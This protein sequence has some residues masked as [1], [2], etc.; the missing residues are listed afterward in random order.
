MTQSATDPEEQFRD[1]LVRYDEA[2]A[3][4][5]DGLIVE[6]QSWSSGLHQEAHQQRFDRV[7]SCLQLLDQD[8]RRLTASSMDAGTDGGA[9]VDES[10]AATS[11]GSPV[12]QQIGRFRL[13]RRLGSGGF[14]MVFLAEDPTLERLVAV[15]IPRPETLA[16]PDLQRRFVQESQLAARLTHP[17]LVPIYEAGQTESFSYQVT[18]Y[19][20]GGNLSQW[21]GPTGIPSGMDPRSQQRDAAEVPASAYAAQRQLSVSVAVELLTTLADGLQY[22]HEHG[23]LHRDLKPSNILLQ[24]RGDWSAAAGR[25]MVHDP[26][27]LEELCTTFQPMISDFGLAKLFAAAGA[28]AQSGDDAPISEL[29]LSTKAGTP[30][31]MAPEQFTGNVRDI[32][33]A[34][35]VYGLGAILYEVLTGRCMFRQNSVESLRYQVTEVQPAGLRQLRRDV[36]RDLEAI[37][38]KCLAKTVPE[39]Y[40][41]ARNLAN[42]LRAFSRGDAVAARPWPWYEQ[43]AK[44][45]KKRPAV[46]SLLIVSSLLM[47]GLLSFGAWHV[48]QLNDLND[49][50][51]LSVKELETHT[52]VAQ[53]ESQRAGHQAR[54]ASEKE[55]LAKLHAHRAAELAWIARSRAYST[56]LLRAAE[57]FQA[58]KI[59]AIGAILQEQ[60]LFPGEADERGFAWHYLWSLGRNM[61]ELPG[62]TTATVCAASLTRDGKTC[63]AISHDGTIR[64]WDALTGILQQMWIL[65]GKGSVFAKIDRDTTRAV[66]RR[67]GHEESLPMVV[68]WDLRQG[69]ELRRQEFSDSGIADVAIAP[70]GSWSL[71]GG[72]SNGIVSSPVLLWSIDSGQMTRMELPESFDRPSYG[73]NAV[74]ISPDGR[75]CAVAVHSS[76]DNLSWIHQLFRADVRY[77]GVGAGSSGPRQPMTAPRISEWICVKPP[78]AGIER[79]LKYSPDGNTISMAVSD[80]HK[81]KVEVWE[82]GSLRLLDVLEDGEREFDEMAF[83][84]PE[85]TLA[86]SGVNHEVKD[87]PSRVTVG[88]GESTDSRPELTFWNVKK[89]THETTSFPALDRITS[90]DFHESSRVWIIGEYEGRLSLWRPEV[91]SQYRDLPGHQ[92]DET[93]GVAFSPDGQTVY[94]VGDDWG[95]RAWNVVTGLQ[96]GSGMHHRSLV[97]CLAVSPDGRWVATGSYDDDVILWDADS[98]SVHSV[99]KGH[100]HDVRSVAFSADSMTVASA[101]R[102]QSIRRWTVPEGRLMGVHDQ[103]GG[104]IRAVSFLGN[105]QLVE[106]NAEGQIRICRPD[107]TCD[108][109]RDELHA[110][111]VYCISVAPAGLKWLLHGAPDV[112]L[113]E[114]LIQTAGNNELL[115]YG[116]RHGALR[117]LHIPSRQVLLEKHLAA[118]EI[119]SVAFSPDGRIAAAAGDDNAVHLFHVATGDEVLTFANLPAAVNQICFSP[120]GRHLAAALHDG[121]I[122]LWDAFVAP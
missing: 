61:R 44:W 114:R 13:I 90:L 42:D 73:V 64:R 65:P 51:V 35:D 7:Q 106:G 36:P 88:P 120:D 12:P 84:I 81:G 3:A 111:E 2:L 94:S 108:L 54:I 15:K 112:P 93:W 53:L 19:C 21:L 47:L 27:P 38:L 25:T 24:P 118:G 75:E 82:R 58:G 49:R 99:L 48:T 86:L 100:T 31:Y 113:Q 79:S 11:A 40:R 83:E 30:Q 101:G 119:R 52:R 72:E 92:P 121:T 29:H 67:N 69:K 41:S 117:L 63:F 23:I 50:L 16:T 17:N 109:L 32:G 62:H 20:A 14:G 95:L 103:H 89:K 71:I 59:S 4:S 55:N 22:A 60:R 6:T 26:V 85:Q 9:Q 122:R 37:C 77:D 45:S 76:S 33:P 116:C 8:R 98:L 70:D 78:S 18:A 5:S 34:T 57:R 102:D 104:T 66:L 68:A 1:L 96:T 115:L 46:A 87:K 43:L 74:A 91:V 107:G 28:G 56:N 80:H 39:R 105:Q 10:P 110:E 97:S